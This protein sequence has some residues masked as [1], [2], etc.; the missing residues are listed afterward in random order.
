MSSHVVSN[1]Q[2]RALDSQPGLE[3][4]HFAGI[5]SPVKSV[6]WAKDQHS[7]VYQLE[8][9][10]KIDA[11]FLSKGNTLSF[12]AT[13]LERSAIS[14]PESER[15]LSPRMQE[16]ELCRGRIDKSVRIIQPLAVAVAEHLQQG[17]GLAMISVCLQ[18][19]TGK[20][21]YCDRELGAVDT[22]VL[23]GAKGMNIMIDDIQCDVK[24]SVIHELGKG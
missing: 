6:Y 5:L 21:E 9:P 24:K 1:I 19:D 13:V 12:E 8:I 16:K 15:L 2:P 20:V 10:I 17:Q 7:F 11:S 4:L 3:Q 18:N 14:G 23:A 22:Q